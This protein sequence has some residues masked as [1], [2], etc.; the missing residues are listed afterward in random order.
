[1]YLQSIL[2]TDFHLKVQRLEVALLTFVLFLRCG[3]ANYLL[4]YLHVQ[5]A[6]LVKCWRTVICEKVIS[7]HFKNASLF[8]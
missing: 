4:P 1:M 8:I 5:P 6:D 2:P 3:K 7:H